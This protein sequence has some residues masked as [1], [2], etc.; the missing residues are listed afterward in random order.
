M[1]GWLRRRRAPSGWEDAPCLRG[2]GRADRARLAPLVDART[3]GRGEALVHEGEPADALY[4]VQEGTLDVSSRG[5]HGPVDLGRVGPGDVLGDVALF[6]DGPRSATAVARARVVVVV[7]PF[8][9]LRGPKAVLSPEGQLT[10]L[11]RVGAGLA[12]RVRAGGAASAEAVRRT[13]VLAQLL[14]S[15]TTLQCLYAITLATLP[16]LAGVL[17][18]STTWVSVPLQLVFGA[19]AVGF[20]ARSRLPLADFGLGLRHLVGSLVLGAIVTVPLLV[21]PT[22]V[23]WG[24]LRAKGLDWPVVAQPDVAAAFA[25]PGVRRLLVAY[26]VS[27]LVQELIVRSALQSSLHLFLRGPRAELRAIAVAALLFATNHL[28]MSPLF[29]A[30]MLVPG[31]VWGYVYARRRHVAGVVL[32]HVVSGA[33]V[34]FVLGPNVG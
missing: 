11:E 17:P 6:D 25:D 21:V 8:A 26:A 16:L 33:Y 29:A 31:F 32:S 14:V 23:K 2:L 12:T 24:L 30:W 27:S 10:V 28:H 5:E 18:G 34:F 19:A 15:V 4:L 3:L 20:L 1:F 22:A 9:A 7:V 13:D